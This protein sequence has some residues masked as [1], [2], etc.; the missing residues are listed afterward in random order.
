MSIIFTGETFSW[1]V[2]HEGLILP[3]GIRPG[4]RTFTEEEWAECRWNPPVVN[5]EVADDDPLVE[6]DTGA[7][8]K[9]LWSTLLAGQHGAL[10][11]FKTGE[12]RLEGSRRIMEAYGETS[13]DDEIQLRLRDGHTPSQ[14]TERE[15]L[16]GK[17]A[18]IKRKLE[19]ATT[20][21]A[22]R[23]IDVTDN[24]LWI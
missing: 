5:F 22:V 17:Y 16:R 9:P 6:F 24:S 13:L 7:S 19:K 11:V 14:D 4:K 21:D 10:V 8:S 20:A 2:E 15:R 3:H 12:L 18:E 23:A 1:L